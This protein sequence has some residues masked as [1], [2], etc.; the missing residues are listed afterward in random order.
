MN[1]AYRK[2]RSIE[3]IG[4]KTSKPKST[5]RNCKA[6]KLR[7]FERCQHVGAPTQEDVITMFLFVDRYSFGRRDSLEDEMYIYI[8]IYISFVCRSYMFYFNTLLLGLISLCCI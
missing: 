2:Y 6:H 3:S 5:F 1:R 4:F 8:Y 7:F